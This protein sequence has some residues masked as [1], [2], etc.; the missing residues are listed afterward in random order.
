MEDSD[1][2]SVS[3]NLILFG[4]RRFTEEVAVPLSETIEDLH[5]R[6]PTSTEEDNWEPG[7]PQG[8]YAAVTALSAFV[9]IVLFVSGWSAK[10]ALDEIYET[11]LKAK[12]RALFAKFFESETY[13]KKYAVC[14]LVNSL[15]QR[16]SIVVAIV[17]K[18]IDEIDL[19][20]RQVSSVMASA[21][22]TARRTCLSD[23]VHLY[24]LEG[25]Q[26]NAHPWVYGS[27][28]EAMRHMSN[29]S[30]VGPIR[31]VRIGS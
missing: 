1:T 23:S 4:Q 16:V 18:D 28:K 31:P 7:V 27:L 13:G 12:L 2:V 30:S 17:G 19:A 29:M 15:E 24:I 5:D 26:V 6:F 25:S 8:L 9:G 22:D 14:L 10:K 3:S 20:Q 11:T 21:M